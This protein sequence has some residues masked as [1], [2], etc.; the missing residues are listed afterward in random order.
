[1]VGELT[2][3]KRLFG[4]WVP[5][6][7]IMVYAFNSSNVQSW[8]IAGFT[9][10]W[11]GVAWHSQEIRDAIWLSVRV[12]LVA[13]ALVAP[14][15]MLLF[16]GVYGRMY[17]MFLFTATLAFLAVN[18][19]IDPSTNYLTLAMTNNGA[20]HAPTTALRENFSGGRMT[21]PCGVRGSGSGSSFARSANRMPHATATAARAKRATT[22]GR[23]TTPSQPMTERPVNRETNPKPTVRMPNT[24]ANAWAAPFQ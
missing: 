23:P 12:A 1:M 20:Q 7:L 13:T 16:H 4:L 5:L 24:T 14:S 2:W 10:K 9:T 8:P 3:R 21:V 22:L 11:F 6:A 18:Y 19:R 17:S 15:W